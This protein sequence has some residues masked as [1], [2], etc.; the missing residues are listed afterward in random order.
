MT[1]DRAWCQCAC[2]QGCHSE[3][4]PWAERTTQNSVKMAIKYCLWDGLV[5]PQTELE[6]Q[7]SWQGSR[8]TWGCH[9][10]LLPGLH[11]STSGPLCPFWGL[12]DKKL[13]SYSTD[14]HEWAPR[15][16]PSCTWSSSLGSGGGSEGRA[17][18]IRV[19]NQRGRTNDPFPAQLKIRMNCT[20]RLWNL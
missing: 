5:S 10:S 3:R 15:G 19:I 13:H 9:H 6:K 8:Q 4:L 17:R 7:E 2:E 20:E 11:Q 16:A 1:A 14:K 12:Q 18:E